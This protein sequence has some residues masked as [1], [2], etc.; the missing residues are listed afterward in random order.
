[1]TEAVFADAQHEI[2]A[3][4]TDEEPSRAWSLLSPW[5]CRAPALGASGELSQAFLSLGEVADVLEQTEI[6]TVAKRAADAPEDARRLLALG[7]A[8]VEYRYAE[9]AFGVLEWGRQQAFDDLVM[10][11]MLAEMVA[12]LE[13]SGDHRGAVALLLE[14]KEVVERDFLCSYLLAF[15]MILAG[16]TESPRELLPRLERKADANAVHMTS[17]IHRM[18]ARS[19]ALADT[20][21]LEAA[22]VR[23]WHYVSTGSVLAGPGARPALLRD[24]YQSIAHGIRRLQVLLD[25]WQLSP[26]VVFGMTDRASQVVARALSQCLGR[27]LEPWMG[28]ERPGLV[29]G[30]DIMASHPKLLEPLRRHRP[31]QLLYAHTA[32]WTIEQPVVADI[33]TT[34]YQQLIAPWQEQPVGDGDLGFA[35]VDPPPDASLDGLAAEVLKALD[36]ALPVAELD[37]LRQFA[38]IVRAGATPPAA[39]CDSGE[40]ERLWVMA[41]MEV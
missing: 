19:R 6:A 41:P 27:P 38:R 32:C 30:Y 22:D 9:E 2:V 37:A 12:A 40:R 21:S 5:L 29:V 26:P 4:L 39:C 18:L 24:S 23:G 33:V 20:S 13:L 15:N 14:A 16:D 8:L 3:A 7:H 1:M 28:D 35:I 34:L 31:G 17:R 36:L 25:V 11:E 10:A